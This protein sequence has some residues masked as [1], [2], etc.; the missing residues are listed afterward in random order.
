MRFF[1]RRLAIRAAALIGVVG[2]LVALNGCGTMKLSD[3]E[4]TTPTLRLEDYFAGESKAWGVFE[5]RFGTL[6][7]QFTVDIFGD[8]DGERLVLTEDFIYSDGE[9]EQRVWT[10]R[11]DGPNS[12]VGSA[13]G[14]IGAARWRGKR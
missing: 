3:F 7:R 9:T 11:P 14:V 8:W 1:T 4:G 2:G 5:D 12:Y 13:E 6:K 10:I